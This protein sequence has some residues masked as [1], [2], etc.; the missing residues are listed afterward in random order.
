MLC[1][2]WGETA[3]WCSCN[4]GRDWGSGCGCTAGLH[5]GPLPTRPGRLL[6]GMESRRE[7]DGFPA[8]PLLLLF[9]IILLCGRRWRT[10]GMSHFFSSVLLY[11]EL[12]L[13]GRELA[14]PPGRSSAVPCTAQGVWC[15]KMSVRIPHR[16]KKDKGSDCSHCGPCAVWNFI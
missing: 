4:Y 3:M 6:W 5:A 14:A 2:P 11:E 13:R 1:F 15:L 9:W 10:A 12:L 16:F 8:T 7:R